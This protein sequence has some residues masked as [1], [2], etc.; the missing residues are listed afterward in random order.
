MPFVVSFASVV[1]KAP[2]VSGAGVVSIGSE[3]TGT[4]PSLESRGLLL[5][6]WAERALSRRS[7]S[8]GRFNGCSSDP[9]RDVVREKDLEE[10]LSRSLSRSFA[11]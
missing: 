6:F 10:R 2:G 7:S 9:R 3:G 8:G 4:P 1:G 5:I 11:K